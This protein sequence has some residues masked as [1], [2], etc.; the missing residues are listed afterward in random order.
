[1]ALEHMALEHMALSIVARRKMIGSESRRPPIRMRISPAARLARL[2]DE[3]PSPPPDATSAAASASMGSGEIDEFEPF[4]RRYERAILN[5]LWRVTGEE[6]T[7]YD[8]AQETFLRAWQ[9]FATISRYEQPR[10]WLFRVAT[11]LALSHNSARQR[12][13]TVTGQVL[14]EGDG[15]PATSDV[16]RRVVERDLVR[17]ALLRLPAK[18]RAALALRELYGLSTAEVAEALG[19][20]EPAVR[21]ALSRAREQF[22]AIYEREEGREDGR[23]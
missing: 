22:R 1:M 10:A 17:E 4:V 16:A 8:L 6:Q 21:M 14:F 3:E 15:S 23:G 12:R 11:N 20:S 13:A 5:Y 18:R 9:R 7:A 19:M 2:A